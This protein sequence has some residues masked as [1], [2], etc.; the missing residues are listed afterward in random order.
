MVVFPGLV[1]LVTIFMVPYIVYMRLE[2]QGI[3]GIALVI[4]GGL[5]LSMF[6]TW[7][8]FPVFKKIAS[9][10]KVSISLEHN[11]ISW[12]AKGGTHQIDLNKPYN[13]YVYCGKSV[14]GSGTNVIVRQNGNTISEI[15]IAMSGFEPNAAALFKD[16]FFAR[17]YALLPS[18]GMYGFDLEKR[19]YRTCC[20]F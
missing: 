19:K 4:V 17:P 8:T 12:D 5:A 3:G 18:E 20:F 15:N 1:F 13:A 16:S 14:E 6:L 11:V 2:Y 9:L 7:V 10:K